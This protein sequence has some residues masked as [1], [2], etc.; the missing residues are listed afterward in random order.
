[1]RHFNHPALKPVWVA[2]AAPPPKRLRIAVC[3]S[4]QLRGFRTAFPTWQALGLDGH[5]VTYFVHTWRNIGIKPLFRTDPERQPPGFFETFERIRQQVADGTLIGLYPSLHHR[6][7]FGAKSP[8]VHF[9]VERDELVALYET[10][11]VVIED[12][13]APE[14]AKFS[15]QEKMF[16]KIA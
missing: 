10:E 6:D 3:V 9:E 15:N 13:E 1:A 2:A 16:H 7:A 14:F 12:D 5:D 4:G 8:L 11:F